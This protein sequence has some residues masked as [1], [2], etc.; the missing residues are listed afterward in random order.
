MADTVYQKYKIVDAHCDTIL[1]IAEGQGNISLENVDGHLD[2]R[3]MI[4]S[5]VNTQFFALYIEPRYKP[6]EA[7]ERTL[8][9]LDHIYDQLSKNSANIELVRNY[10]DIERIHKNN[11]IAVLL[12]IEGGEAIKENTAFL[13]MFYH[14]GIR[15]MTLTWNQRNS[16]GSGVHEGSRGGLSKFGKTVVQEMNRL[17]MLVDVSHLNYEGFWD[18]IEYSKKPIIASHSNA[19]SLCDTP[20][21][22]DD[23]QIKA[24]AEKDG[25]ICCTFVPD[26][27]VKNTQ[28]NL[29]H[30]IDHI[31][32][33]KN[34]VGI[35][36]IGLGSDFDGTDKMPEGLE[37]VG[38]YQSLITTLHARGYKDGQIEKIMGGN[39]LRLLKNVII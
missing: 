5:G 31:S 23:K 18:V 12:S 38:K 17:G 7:L 22:L 14:L 28:A 37:D 15:S 4:E 39:I 34:L 20:R 3:R 19:K 9:L 11:K 24:M 36:H 27:L 33:M 1:K 10:S 32:Y 30:V 8:V 26:F 35:N 29:S 21:N 6:C 16:I 2:I 13:R 25:V